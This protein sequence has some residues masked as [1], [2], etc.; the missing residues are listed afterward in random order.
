MSEA[1]A[2]V[3]GDSQKQAVHLEVLGPFGL[4]ILR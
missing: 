4:K 2:D 1:A 3:R